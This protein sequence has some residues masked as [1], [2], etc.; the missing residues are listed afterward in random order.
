MRLFIA[1]TLPKKERQRLLRASASLRKTELPVRWV[2]VDSIHLTLKFLGEVAPDRVSRVEE[3]MTR[4]ASKSRP[5]DV[6]LG[7]F[8]AFPSL[9]K[10]RVIWAGAY[11]SPE[12]RCLKHDLEWELA[13]LGYERE[14]RAF[15]PHIT[16]GRALP[17]ATVGHFRD[18]EE[19]VAPLEFKGEVT[20]KALH[21][22]RSAL[23]AAGARYDRLATADLGGA[24]PTDDED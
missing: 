24:L 15:H 2:D 3:A 17:E 8:G 9:R 6:T 7:G 16:V 22:M 21:L 18:L 4:V 19:Q 13:S 11:A 14:A 1:V 10:P 5:F 20:V 12:L 23:H